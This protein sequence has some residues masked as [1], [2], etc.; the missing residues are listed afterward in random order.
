M[1]GQEA[2]YASYTILYYTSSVICSSSYLFL[3]HFLDMCGSSLFGDVFGWIGN[4]VL[5]IIKL[6]ILD[7]ALVL[8][9]GS[10]C[11]YMSTILSIC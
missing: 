7:L 2:C 8:R 11:R 10:P 4:V 5:I 1:L 3:S 9:L 6:I